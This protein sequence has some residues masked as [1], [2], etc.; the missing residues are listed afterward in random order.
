MSKYVFVQDRSVPFPSDQTAPIFLVDN[1]LAA[2][3]A[4]RRLAARFGWGSAL[5]AL[6]KS[7]FPNR[8]LF[9]TPATGAIASSGGIAIGFCNF[10][11]VERDAVVIGT[12][13]TTAPNQGRGLATKMIKAAMNM[14]MAR[15]YTRFYIDTHTTNTPMLRSIEKL[16]FGPPNRTIE[17]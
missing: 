5:R 9:F 13:E 11:Q 8:I 17:G 16:G 3:R 7:L 14:M 2:T 1:P 6:A 15:G 12:I 4:A 10:Y